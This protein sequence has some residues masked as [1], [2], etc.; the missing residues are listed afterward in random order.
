MPFNSF[1]DYPMS[2]KPKRS[3]LKRPIYQSLA[4][5][6]EKDIA[7]GFLVPETK[8]PPQR[9][10]ADFLDINF[11]TVTRAY[12]LC[13]LK[14]LIYAVTGSGTFV[15]PNAA[16]SVTISTE[17]LS[18][19]VIDLGFVSSFESCNAMIPDT[20]VSV[21]K[22]KQISELLDYKS[23]TG[24]SHHKSAGVNWL[25]NIG[26]QTDTEHLAIVS[27]TQNGLAL[28]LLALFESGNRIAVDTYTYA[29]LIELAKM[30]HLQLIPI[31]G[32]MEGMSAEELEWQHK[33]TPLHGIFLMP[34]CC[35][36]TTVMISEKRKQELAN[37]IKK[38]HLIL[39]ED[40][41]HAFL[42]AGIIKDYQGSM[43]RLLPEQTI[44][45]CG[46]SK[47][48]CSGL[49][50]AYLVFPDTFRSRLQKAIFNINVKTS[51]LDAEIITELIVNGTAK[52]IV[53]RKYQ[54]AQQ[55]NQLFYN[56]FPEYTKT[57]HPFSFFRW[58]PIESTASGEEFE[59]HLLECGIRVY[60]S[61]RFLYGHTQPQKFLRVSLATA[62][63]LEQ[64]K[65]GLLIL[66][67]NLI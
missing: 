28:S 8:L 22:K 44:Y 34:S 14:G 50:V 43:S 1:L 17:N 32:D 42:T 37:V 67:E 26:V 25:Q 64:L 16:K 18:H 33:Q 29:N 40:D 45:L 13:E 4:E 51:S 53:K 58:L 31:A 30:F 52:K 65:K 63:S 11:T 41:I 46:T 48:I 12:R 56:I 7:K 9:E 39:I 66:R 21:A 23:P 2:W 36:P 20:L 5:Q 3:Q 54:L 27:G 47:S 60:H 38:H 15:S 24:M 59:H 62:P 35:N 49:R 55:T 57:G 19:A 10:L 6:L 61:D